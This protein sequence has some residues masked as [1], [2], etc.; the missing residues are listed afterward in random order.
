MST[1][2]RR[3]AGCCIVEFDLLNL[4]SSSTTISLGTVEA[5]FWGV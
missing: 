4:L 2:D 5:L 1:T 3:L